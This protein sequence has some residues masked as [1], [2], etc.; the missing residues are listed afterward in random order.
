MD[1]RERP[2]GS[3]F[4]TLCLVPVPRLWALFSE[5]VDTTSSYSRASHS[6]LQLHGFICIQVW[7]TCRVITLVS[8]EKLYQS[9]GALL[10]AA[11]VPVLV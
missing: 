3:G 11:H 4:A 7:Y 10:A 8:D 1:D 9:L 5:V 2:N 6:C